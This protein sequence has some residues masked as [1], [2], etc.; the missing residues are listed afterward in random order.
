MLKKLSLDEYMD[1]IFLYYEANHK[2]GVIG[3]IFLLTGLNNKYRL[4]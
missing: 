3:V 4:A 2:T 1:I